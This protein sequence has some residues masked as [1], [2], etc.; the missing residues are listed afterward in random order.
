MFEFSSSGN[1]EI[2]ENKP[3]LTFQSKK[4][5]QKLLKLNNRVG[6]LAK[7]TI[8]NPMSILVFSP[9]EFEAFSILILQAA[10]ILYFT[11]VKS[12][13]LIVLSFLLTCK[14]YYMQLH[15]WNL[16][17]YYEGFLMSIFSN[18][19]NSKS[20][21]QDSTETDSTCHRIW[22]AGKSGPMRVGVDG[23]PRIG[24]PRGSFWT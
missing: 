6:F 15:R 24:C 4:I 17:F 8:P 9:V 12:T 18:V 2:C 23:R 3:F 21:D 1:V 19:R 20:F 10:K 14:Y 13:S 22:P 11:E 7:P 5:D 16:K